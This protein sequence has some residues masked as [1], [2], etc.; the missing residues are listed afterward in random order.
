[1]KKRYWV[2]L[3]LLLALA[4]CF[5]D[6]AF[7]LDDIAKSTLEY[8]GEA[9]AGV[10][11][12]VSGVALSVVRGTLH[13]DGLTIGNPDGFDTPYFVALRSS[14][15]EFSLGN[16]F[17]DHVVVPRLTIEGVDLYLENSE[18]GE[19][20]RV[21]LDHMKTAEHRGSERTEQAGKRFVIREL[22]I[23]G[24]VA[25]TDVSVAGKKL[26]EVE[27]KIDEIRLR[28]VGSDTDGGAV[29]SELMGTIVIAT[30]EAVIRS[31]HEILPEAVERGVGV[32]L[33][34]VVG[35]VGAVEAV[36][37]AVEAIDEGVKGVTKGIGGILGGG[38]KASQKE[39]EK[40]K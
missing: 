36:H 30:L 7:Y 11:T 24:I 38:K 33:A 3:L 13:I 6:V 27:L 34:Q 19:N 1:M 4:L 20:Y 39:N 23:R 22:L 32:G 17:A 9:V 28:D 8:S 40:P 37:G 10:P 18:R 35:V 16:L 29:A 15:C 21:I 25:H 5:V 14:S 2:P 26:T 12:T 31:G